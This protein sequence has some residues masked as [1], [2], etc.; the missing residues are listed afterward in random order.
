[1]RG[2]GGGGGR[3]RGS[4]GR[5]REKGRANGVIATL[6]A[7]LKRETGVKEGVCGE[8]WLI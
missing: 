8:H 3:T 4:K 1:M 2:A 7:E 5:E 6:R